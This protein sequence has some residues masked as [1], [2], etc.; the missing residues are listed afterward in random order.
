M[1]EELVKSGTIV[2]THKIAE[3]MLSD[4]FPKYLDIMAFRNIVT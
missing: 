4:I 1:L 3:H 2:V